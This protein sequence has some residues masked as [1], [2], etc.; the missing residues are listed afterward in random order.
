MTPAASSRLVEVD[1][2]GSLEES[3]E[4]PNRI[5]IASKVTVLSSPKKLCSQDRHSSPRSN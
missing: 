4:H 3:S 5:L 1:D 2:P